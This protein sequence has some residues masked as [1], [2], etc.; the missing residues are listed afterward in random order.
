MRRP[1]LST[2]SGS[3][4]LRHRVD[5]ALSEGLSGGRRRAGLHSLHRG[6]HRVFGPLRNLLGE[7]PYQESG[8]SMDARRGS[9][10]VTRAVD[11]PFSIGAVSVRSVL[12][13][14][15]MVGP[16]STRPCDDGAQRC[17]TAP[18]GPPHSF[19]RAGTG[20]GTR[21]WSA[22]VQRSGRIWNIDAQRENA[23][24]TWRANLYVGRGD[25]LAGSSPILRLAGNR[26]TS[27]RDRISRA[28]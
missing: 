15:W 26:P 4:I 6:N 11:V 18:L 8:S 23:V 10:F 24:A 1:F 2:A 17:G 13:E 16:M 14:R 27:Y 28:A 25:V 19:I 5:E 22:T 9:A 21:Q 3:L 12:M 20:E 7:P